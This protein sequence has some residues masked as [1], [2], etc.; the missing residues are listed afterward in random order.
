[1]AEVEAN[2]FVIFGGT[3]DLAERKLLPSLFRAV[4][5]QGAADRSVVLGVSRHDIGDEAYRKWTKEV[6]KAAEIIN[7][8]S[9]RW[10]DTNVYHQAVEGGVEGYAEL[11]KRIEAIESERGLPR[12]RVLYLATPPQAFAPTIEGLGHSGLNSS[13][14]WTRIV[15]EKPFGTDL[16]T[17]RELNRLALTHFDESQIY[18]IDHYLGKATVQNLLAFRFTNPMFERLWNRDRVAHVEITVAETLGIG[19]RADYYDRAGAIRDIVQNHLTQILALVA[20]EPP[21]VFEAD[22]IRDEKVK[23]MKAIAPIEPDD[24]VFAQYESG[25][26]REGAV[27]GYLHEKG[28]PPESKTPT[29]VGIRMYVDSWRWQGIPFLLR[30]GKRLPEQFTRIAV[31]FR[32]PA[33]CV[34]HGRR[35]DCVMNPDVLFI[36][37]QPDE[38]F[39]LRFNVRSPEDEA[40]LDSQA[41]HFRYSD[42]YGELRDAYE[43]LIL[44]ILEGDQTLFVRGD[45]VEASWEVYD[46]LLRREVEPIRYAAGTWGP[47]EMSQGVPMGGEEWTGRP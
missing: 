29:F 4:A 8:D 27:L 25:D 14:G 23:V 12:N 44:D 41:L 5:G 21:N 47:P 2:L 20:M 15:L 36:I 3:G 39:S 46:P 40:K 7:E 16:E 33:L 1:M 11:R 22:Q 9:G 31:T 30:T 37:L 38:G 24:V 6:L 34:F 35:D 26:M 13:D 45:E 28:V 42:V 43:T 32:E 17:A 19:R 10:C 18:R